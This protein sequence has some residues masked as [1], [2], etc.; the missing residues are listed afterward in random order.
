MTLHQ[1]AN[2]KTEALS[3]WIVWTK[4]TAVKTYFLIC[5]WL[6]PMPVLIHIDPFSHISASSILKVHE[7]FKYE[8]LL[9][10]A[11]F[12]FKVKCCLGQLPESSSTVYSHWVGWAGPGATE[13]MA[14][15]HS[16]SATANGAGVPKGCW[17]ALAMMCPRKNTV[18]SL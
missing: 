6:T 12:K 15:L 10:F 7:L 4:P 17:A 5:S 18:N 13:I 9:Q 2:G 14:W 11:F 3:V 8:F 16:H 1:F